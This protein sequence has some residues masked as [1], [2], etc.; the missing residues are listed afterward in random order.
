MTRMVPPYTVDVTITRYHPN[1]ENKQTKS[2]LPQTYNQFFSPLHNHRVDI[3][4]GPSVS[5]EPNPTAI[6]VCTILDNPPPV[7]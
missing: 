2:T 7:L 6:L 4:V 1:I 5:Y 3:S